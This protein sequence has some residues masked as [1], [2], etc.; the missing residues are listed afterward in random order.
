MSA[1][2][3][4][5]QSRVPGVSRPPRERR[6]LHRRSRPRKGPRGARRKFSPT[7]TTASCARTGYLDELFALRGE[8]PPAPEPGIAYGALGPS[9]K[10]TLPQRLAAQLADELNA[11]PG[12]R[13]EDVSLFAALGLLARVSDLLRFVTFFQEAAG[14]GR[15][16]G[17]AA[18]AAV[19]PAA[20]AERA[21]E[22]SGAARSFPGL[23]RATP[24]EGSG[25]RAAHVTRTR[26][27]TR[28]RAQ[29]VGCRYPAAGADRSRTRPLR[30]R[31]PDRRSGGAGRRRDAR[32]SGSLPPR[33]LAPSARAAPR[34]LRWP[35]RAGSPSPW[36]KEPNP[37]S[38]HASRPWWPSGPSAAPLPRIRRPLR[39]PSGRR[40][41]TSTCS[42]PRSCP[43]GTAPRP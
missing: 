43:Q 20:E 37:P 35:F 27:Q 40:R 7:S 14:G 8:T 34:R 32:P 24:V 28:A 9:L 18:D 39:P 6:E 25:A 36:P 15:P 31:H 23:V 21:E 17:G 38:G 30:L 41:T 11:L 5:L 13:L 3:Q 42:S 19:D 26:A 22:L 2:E 10:R 29:A 16:A 12:R 4:H 33:G 1:D